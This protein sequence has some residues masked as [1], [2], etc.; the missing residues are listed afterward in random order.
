MFEDLRFA[1]ELFKTDFSAL[2]GKSTTASRNK[3]DISTGKIH[4]YKKNNKKKALF[5]FKEK[6]NA[7]SPVIV[8]PPVRADVKSSSS[9]YEFEFEALNDPYHYTFFYDDEGLGEVSGE[10][11]RKTIND[12]LH[13][14]SK[15]K[16]DW[17]T[18]GD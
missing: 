6:K 4:I 14:P 18:G 8:L 1:F 16:G 7:D 10:W 12:S 3:V 9:S 11:I 15:D 17:G 5:F 2:P 13:L